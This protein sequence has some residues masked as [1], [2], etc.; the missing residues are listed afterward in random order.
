[1]NESLIQFFTEDITYQIRRKRILRRGIE[2]VVSEKG[3]QLG[4][5]NIIFCSDRFLRRFNVKFLRHN[6]YT[7]V[8]AFNLSDQAKEITGDIFISL[9]RVRENARKYRVTVAREIARVIIHGILH[10][11]G[12]DDSTTELKRA[13]KCEEDKFISKLVNA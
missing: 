13:M 3:Y 10:L 12:M 9:E 6:Y 2:Q 8:I 5:V 11:T 1:M 7:D 4:S